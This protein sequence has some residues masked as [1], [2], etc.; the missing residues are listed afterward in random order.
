MESSA[1]MPRRKKRVR[2][3]KHVATAVE[4][5]CPHFFVLFSEGIGLRR[6]IYRTDSTIAPP[7]NK[8]KRFSLTTVSRLLD[9][10]KDDIYM[11][12]KYIFTYTFFVCEG[13]SNDGVGVAR[14]GHRISRVITPVRAGFKTDDFVRENLGD[15]LSQKNDSHIH[16]WLGLHPQGQ[17][18]SG[19][20]SYLLKRGSRS[21]ICCI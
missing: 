20:L 2:V 3:S 4:R 18:A 14:G 19:R 15:G 12:K 9:T 1:S 17:N 8:K 16:T 13:L 11:Q 5:G 7:P 21:T 10:R 6:R